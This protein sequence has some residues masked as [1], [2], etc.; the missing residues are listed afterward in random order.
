MNK[1]AQQ[2]RNLGDQELLNKAD[3]LRKSIYLL[4]MR[5]STK[6]LQNIA[7]IKK[8]RRELAR[9]KT[10]LRQKGIKI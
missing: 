8:E 6:E 7:Q 2:I 9:V 10:I 1:L 5:A 4:R 3:E